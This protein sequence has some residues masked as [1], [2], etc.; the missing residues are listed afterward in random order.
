MLANHALR[1]KKVIVFYFTARFAAKN[2]T[3]YLKEAYE[4]S[5]RK[6]FPASYTLTFFQASRVKDQ[7]A[8]VEV[9]FVSNV[10]YFHLCN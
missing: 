1:D 8:G 10:R 7:G 3:P 4:V 2:F 9:I 6:I 5:R